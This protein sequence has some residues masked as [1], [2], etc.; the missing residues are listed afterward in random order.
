MS[1][2]TTMS[3]YYV[4]PQLIASDDKQNGYYEFMRWRTAWNI[5]SFS[6]DVFIEFFR[7]AVKKFA[8][9]SL[10]V[11]FTTL[12]NTMQSI[13]NVNIGRFAS[14]KDFLS[15]IGPWDT[16]DQRS[17]AVTGPTIGFSN[18]EICKFLTKAPD[19]QYLAIKVTICFE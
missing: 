14:L 3:L 12:K 17:Q 5:N 8:P 6:E 10:P 1:T 13:H 9:S 18:D 7:Q 11:I 16:C 4:V 15:Q 19:F 2:E